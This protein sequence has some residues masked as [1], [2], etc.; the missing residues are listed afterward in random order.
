MTWQIV[1]EAMAYFI[2]AEALIQAK[3]VLERDDRN[4]VTT[5]IKD[6]C[7]FMILSQSADT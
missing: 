6:A 3:K 2:R 1:V 4:F 5:E 7:P